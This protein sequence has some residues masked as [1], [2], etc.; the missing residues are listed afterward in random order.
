MGQNSLPTN[1]QDKATKLLQQD[2]F[3]PSK[4]EH[5][6]LARQFTMD[7][8]FYTMEQ[9]TSLAEFEYLASS[10]ADSSHDVRLYL[11][12]SS[13]ERIQTVFCLP[14]YGIHIAIVP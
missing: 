10:N 12:D 14:E 4:T 8:S 6:Q 5:F 2:Y 11:I 13:N 7:T 1:H 9:S 3:C